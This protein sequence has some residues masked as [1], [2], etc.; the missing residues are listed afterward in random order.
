M[1][2]RGLQ[3]SPRFAQGFGGDVRADDLV[4][5]RFAREAQQQLAAAAA[6]VEDAARAAAQQLPYDRIQSLFVEIRI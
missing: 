3:Q 6:Q 5:L 4:E 2:F 1:R